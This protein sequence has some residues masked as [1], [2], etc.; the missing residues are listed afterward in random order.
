MADHDDVDVDLQPQFHQLKQHNSKNP[1]VLLVPLT[2]SRNA[3]EQVLIEPSIN[4]T[5]I[6]IKIK[7]A[8]E[9]E[10]ILAHKVGIASILRARARAI[11]SVIVR[12][13]LC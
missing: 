7:Q 8:D 10:E 6:S 9:I 12:L 13:T 3:N 5:R 4:S 11:A 1:E 2:V